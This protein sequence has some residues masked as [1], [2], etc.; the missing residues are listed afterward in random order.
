M[1]KKTCK[2]FLVVFGLFS[3]KMLNEYREHMN[4]TV[5]KAEDIA[6]FFINRA[7][8]EYVDEGGVAEG[9]TNLKLQK[10]LYFAQA[11]HLSMYGK[12]L[13]EDEIEAWKFGPV[14]RSVYDQYKANGNSPIAECVGIKLEDDLESFLE[15]VWSIY[16]KY[17]ASELVQITHNHL[18]WKEAYL[19]KGENEIIKQDRLKE[20]YRS[21]FTADEE[22]KN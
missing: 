2:H 6:K 15:S 3:E 4:T 12:P 14:V 20:Y 10:M 11:A 1:N 8:K 22:G 9:I 21:Y 19:G 13:F 7:N 16:G 17:S 18:P 5:H